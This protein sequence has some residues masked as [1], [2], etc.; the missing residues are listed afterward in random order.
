VLTTIET[1]LNTKGRDVWS[2]TPDA[3]VRDAIELMAVKRV[4]ALLVL[5]DQTLVGI[6]SE[7]DCARQVTLRGR[8]PEDVLISDIMSSPVVCVTPKHTIGDCMRITNEK[9]F[10]H[11]PVLDGERVAGIVS[12]GD[13]VN[14]IVRE[15]EHT[16]HYLEAYVT[17]KYPG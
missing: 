6:V 12:V 13:L 11:L 7:R 8:R 3:T 17:G 10:A 9:G 1:V 15:Q 2:V 16:I 5:V 14:S 4:E